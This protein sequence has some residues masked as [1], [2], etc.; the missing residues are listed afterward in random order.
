MLFSLSRRGDAPI[1]IQR[2]IDRRNRRVHVHNPF[3][4]LAN[5]LGLGNRVFEQLI[6]A[7]AEHG[8]SGRHAGQQ[9]EE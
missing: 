1:A 2:R 5:A 8:I 6:I 7:D 4:E 9:S 3:E